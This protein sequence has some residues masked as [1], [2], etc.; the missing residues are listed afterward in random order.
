VYLERVYIH[1][2][3]KRLLYLFA[4]CNYLVGPIEYVPCQEK[5]RSASPWE[6][7]SVSAKKSHDQRLLFQNRR[8]QGRVG[9]IVSVNQ[10]ILAEKQFVDALG[11]VNLRRL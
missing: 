1:P 11:S 4:D 9:Y 8:D 5:V 2:I 7:V 10:I 6:Y 3:Y